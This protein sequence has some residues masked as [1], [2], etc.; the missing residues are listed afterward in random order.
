MHAMNW[1][2][3]NPPLRPRG[4]G[5]LRRI[6][7]VLWSLLFAGYFSLVAICTAI[8]YPLPAAIMLAALLLLALLRSL[9]SK[10]FSSALFISLNLAL[11]VGVF[12]ALGPLDVLGLTVVIVQATV[13]A[14][15]F[16]SLRNGRTD[17]VTQIALAIRAERSARELAYTR[18]VACAWAWFMAALAAI[19]LAVALGAPPRLWWWWEN[20]GSAALPVAFFGGEWLLRQYVLRGEKKTELAPALRAL[21]RIDYQRLFQV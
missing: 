19:S 1:S 9:A 12:L 5:P 18:R 10:N 11:V 13:S 3:D 6:A 15:F 21:A 17:L 14:L 2:A 16:R 7:P 20:V 8:G 4:R